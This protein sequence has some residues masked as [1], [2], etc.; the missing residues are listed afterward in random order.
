MK[1]I[2]LLSLII[3]SSC[4]TS[5]KKES[6]ITNASKEED[7]SIIDLSSL[8]IGKNKRIKVLEVEVDEIDDSEIISE[9]TNSINIFLTKEEKDFFNLGKKAPILSRFFS[10]PLLFNTRVSSHYGIRKGKIHKGID[11][12]APKNTSIIASN[13]GVVSFSGKKTGYG[14]VIILKHDNNI[15]TIYAHNS[16]NL[17]SN[18]NLIKK[19]Q[20]IATIGST[21]RSTGNHL[22]FEIRIGTNAVDPIMFIKN[23]KR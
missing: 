20:N 16:S 1:Y 9:I 5:L 13:D 17:V 12:P 18:G 21:G 8:S 11:I 3:S 14:N 23:Q 7:S 10:W 6:K 22:H 19:G 4:S 2:L 15:F